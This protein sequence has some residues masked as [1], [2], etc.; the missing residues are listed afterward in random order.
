MK[1][2]PVLAPLPF[3]SFLWMTLY[4]IK[5]HQ[6]QSGVLP[7]RLSTSVCT[8]SMVSGPFIVL[9]TAHKG[10][11]TMAF[12]LVKGRRRQTRVMSRR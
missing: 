12:Y 7:V 1:A 3:L 10:P 11:E 4:S 8:A 6:K 9:T 5:I 2:W